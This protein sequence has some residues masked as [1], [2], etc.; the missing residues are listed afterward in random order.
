MKKREAVD[1]ILKLKR[2]ANHPDTPAH[3]AATAVE[4]VEELMKKHKLAEEDLKESEPLEQVFRGGAR[5]Q[6]TLIPGVSDEYI[7]ELTWLGLRSIFSWLK[8]R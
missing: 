2:L 3:E 6:S 7:K 1:V 4:R 8:R 5:G